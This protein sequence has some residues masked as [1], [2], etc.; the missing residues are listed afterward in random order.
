MH[1][2]SRFIM[3]RKQKVLIHAKPNPELPRCSQHV[4]QQ[5]SQFVTSS[6]LALFFFLGEVCALLL[7]VGAL[8]KHI[9]LA[10]A[11]SERTWF[12]LTTKNIDIRRVPCRYRSRTELDV[13]WPSSWSRRCDVHILLSLLVS[14]SRGPIFKWIFSNVFGGDNWKICN[15]SEYE[16]NPDFEGKISTRYLIHNLMYRSIWY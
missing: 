6:F 5:A 4:V 2:S 13:A 15:T 10:T 8:Y 11:K 12:Y 1:V 7:R 3:Q 9:S 14:S 16:K